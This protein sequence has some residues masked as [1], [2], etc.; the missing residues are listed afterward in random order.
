M[1]EHHETRQA[2]ETD[3]I[4]MRRALTLAAMGDPGASPNPMVGAVIVAGD[5]VIG[6]GFHARCGG[7]HAEVRAMESVRGRELIPGS[8][9]YV[10]LEPCAHY[11]KTPP[12]A[13]L[14]VRERVGRVVIGTVDPFAR[15][16][17]RGIAMLRE[18]GI[19]V[20]VGVLQD[21]CRWINRR[22]FTAHTCHRPY[23]TLKWACSSDGW[24]DHRRTSATD[25]AARF[26]TP[27]TTL[28]VMRLRASHDAVAVGS[29]TVLADDPLLTVRGV[30]GQSPVRVLF[31][32][33][34]RIGPA[35]RVMNDDGVR[36]IHVTDDKPLGEIL[37]DLYGMGITS[38]LVEGG[39]ELLQSFIDAGLWDEIHR[40]IAP[41]ILGARGTVAAPSIPSGIVTTEIRDGNT[42]TIVYS[43]R[44]AEILA[45]LVGE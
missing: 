28:D 5:N 36:V 15:V 3:R 4:Y 32:R 12:C 21:E 1:T 37:T 40:E 11:G 31:D 35:H 42:V 17:G 24:M 23:V 41:V 6:E 16:D 10:T 29:G 45:R 38:L 22:F 44:F 33:R 25:Q 34:R 9:V 7:P 30:A 27:V 2:S 13:A 20:T 26:S 43:L 39:A 8:T 14:L 19:E 18:A